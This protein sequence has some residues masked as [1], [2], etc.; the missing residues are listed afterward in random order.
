MLRFNA[1]CQ[2]LELCSFVS[3]ILSDIISFCSNTDSFSDGGTE[4]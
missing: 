4:R 2:L 3:L 1:G